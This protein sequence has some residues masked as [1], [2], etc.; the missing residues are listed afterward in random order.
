MGKLRGFTLVELMVVMAIFS[1]ISSAVV[2]VYFQLVQAA[3]RATIVAE[4]EQ[5][6]SYAMEV[7]VRDIRQAGCAEVNEGALSLR[8]AECAEVA[9][10]FSTAEEEGVTNLVKTVLDGED[11]VDY[12]LNNPNKTSVQSLSFSVDSSGK[13]A[14]ID[15]VMESVRPAGHSQF[16]GEMSLHETV[17]LRKY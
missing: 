14:T 2:M 6:A 16:R 5:N 8:D 4:V 1:V 9:T 3:N 13:S 17:S 15:L 12:I 11:S 10:V 7:M